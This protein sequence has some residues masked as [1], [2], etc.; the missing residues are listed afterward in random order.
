MN[1]ALKLLNQN[2]SK[3]IKNFE[4]TNLCLFLSKS[5]AMLHTKSRIFPITVLKW[6]LGNLFVFIRA[7]IALDWSQ[8]GVD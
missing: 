1:L 5:M 2:W 6:F 8:I 7:N 3:Q 4:S